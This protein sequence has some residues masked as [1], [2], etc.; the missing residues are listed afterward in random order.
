MKPFN[1]E[2]AK[3]GK[4]VCTREGRDARILWFDKKDEFPIVAL[5]GGCDV[6][7]YKDNGLYYECTPH[8]YD[9]FMKTEDSEGW[10]NIYRTE[11]ETYV[12]SNIYR[13]EEEAIREGKTSERYVATCKI[14][15][16]E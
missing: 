2:Q 5:V 15:W 3:A 9:L 7:T 13:T 8:P 4:P 14:T 16:E 12:S 11:V 1:I 6:L 10:I